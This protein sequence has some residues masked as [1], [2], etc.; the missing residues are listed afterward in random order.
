MDKLYTISKSKTRA[1]C[2]SDHEFLLQNSDLN[3]RKQGKPLDHSGMTSVINKSYMNYKSN[4]LW[5]YSGSDKMIQGISSDRRVPEELQMEVHII[6]QEAVIK[7]HP[8]EKEMPK[9]KMVVWRGLTNNWEKKRNESQGEKER[10]VHLNA[11]FQRIAGEIRKPSLVI[12]AKRQR[13]TIEWE[14]LE[15]SSRKLEMPRELFM[16]RWAQ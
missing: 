14:R 12:N 16:Q 9:G 5:L 4:V 3:W 7:N 15:N 1:D 8:Q 2:S 13:K 11:E 10:Y 6:V